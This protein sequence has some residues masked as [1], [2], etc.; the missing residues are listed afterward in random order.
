MPTARLMQSLL[1][2]LQTHET[3]LDRN[4]VIKNSSPAFW[5]NPTILYSGVNGS[6][7]QECSVRV[8]CWTDFRPTRWIRPS[9][10]RP[11][12]STGPTTGKPSR[13]SCWRWIFASETVPLI[14][15][16]LL[17]LRHYHLFVIKYSMYCLT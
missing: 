3:A 2:V 17:Y 5:S 1:P 8:P 7:P 14:G 10:N 6:C 15:I 9:G 13:P 11:C 4:F 16:Y 12:K